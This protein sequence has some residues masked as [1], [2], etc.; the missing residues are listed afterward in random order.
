MYDVVSFDVISSDS[1]ER[2]FL[3]MVSD[4]CTCEGL[5]LLQLDSIG[6]YFAEI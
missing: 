1:F 5:L 2:Q 3:G 6:V 4:L